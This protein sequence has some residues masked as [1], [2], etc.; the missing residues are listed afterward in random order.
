MKSDYISR[1]KKFIPVIDKI[2]DEYF[3]EEYCIEQSTRAYNYAHHRNVVFSHGLTRYAFI[4]SDYVIKIDYDKD[5]V[6]R[7]GGCEREYELYQNAVV[8]GMD[9]LFAEITPFMYNNKVYYIMPRIK[10]IGRTDYYDATYYM[11]KEEKNWCRNWGLIDLHYLN[12]GWRN[13][14]ICI[15]DYAAH[16]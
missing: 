8:D 9:Y 11:N 4:T 1:A 5:E 14:H 2:L 15:I 3:G 6:E 7:W 16:A 13:K 10:G 12:Y